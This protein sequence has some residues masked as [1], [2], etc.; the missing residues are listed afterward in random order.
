MAAVV[1]IAASHA[2]ARAWAREQP[3][4]PLRLVV[5]TPHSPDAARGVVAD[6]VLST[7]AGRAAK[8]YQRLLE[9]S[10]PSVAAR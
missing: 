1:L 8:S 2:D 9:V 10:L 5:V 3:A 7:S 6:A 4:A